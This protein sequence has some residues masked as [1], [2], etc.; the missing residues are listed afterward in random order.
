MKLPLKRIYHH[1]EK[2]EDYKNGMFAIHENEEI[3]IPQ[4]VK[5][6]SDYK[7]FG[8]GMDRVVK[9]WPLACEHNL[10]D[11]SMNRRAWMGQAAVCI[12]LGVPETV[13]RLAWWQ[14]SEEQRNLANAEAD[15]VIKEWEFCHLTKTTNY[16][17]T[18]FGF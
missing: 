11:N 9:E 1:Y 4:A 12:S 2:W 15:R 18:V 14:L 5:F 6:M 7:L 17:Q 16:A 13:T 10:T 3:L 8:A